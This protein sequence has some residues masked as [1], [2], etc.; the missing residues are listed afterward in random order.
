MHPSPNRGGSD[1]PPTSVEVA[2]TEVC[3]VGHFP[4]HEGEVGAGLFHRVRLPQ[5]ITHS[6]NQSQGEAND[7]ITTRCAGE[8]YSQVPTCM[9]EICW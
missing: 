3:V 8:E 2:V 9:H 5:P 7:T 1:R 6:H 4:E